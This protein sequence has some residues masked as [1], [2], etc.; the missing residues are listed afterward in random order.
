M[1]ELDNKCAIVSGGSGDI[2]RTIAMRLAELG[3]NV[4]IAGRTQAKLDQVSEQIT[5]TTSSKVL[6][7]QCDMRKASE[8]AALVER[9]VS[10]FGRLDIVITCAGDFTRGNVVSIPRADWEDGF[11]LM[12][13]SAVSLV[14]EAW[15][16]LKKSNGHIVMIGGVH[17]IEPHAESLIGGAICAALINF[18]KGASESGRKDGVSVNCV[19]A[20]YLEGRR[21]NAM[22]DKISREQGIARDQAPKVFADQLGVRRLG[23]PQDVANVV[24]LLVSEKGSYFQGS[25][26]VM[27]GGVTHGR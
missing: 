1:P 20:G 10:E 6:V 3:A 17:G 14:S 2:G 18:A 9:T 22:L 12:F 27:D 19:V 26:I 24:E 7:T 21:V 13:H 25:A 23:T 11:D 4:S 16:H 15:P 5:K 8:P